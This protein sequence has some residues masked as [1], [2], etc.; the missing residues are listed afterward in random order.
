MKTLLNY[1]FENNYDIKHDIDMLKTSKDW[2]IRS[3]ME[4]YEDEKDNKRIDY[5]DMVN[6]SE[7]EKT[8]LVAYLSHAYAK[9][10]NA[11]RTNAADNDTIIFTKL[12]NNI[13][14][15]LKT[16]KGVCYRGIVIDSGIKRIDTIT[17]GNLLT[18]YKHNEGKII[19]YKEF[20]SCGKNKDKIIRKFMMSDNSLNFTILS[21]TGKDLSKYNYEEEEILFKTNTKFKVVN[22]MNN[23]IKLEEI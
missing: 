8:I 16:Y 23:Y 6:L 10:N 18:Y 9:V 14:S 7:A 20:L 1:L 21:K 2:W 12:L 22:V 5:S 3:G 4:T 13:L 11:L 17:Y 15:K 19:E